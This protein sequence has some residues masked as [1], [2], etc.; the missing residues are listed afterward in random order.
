[1]TDRL[2][3]VHVVLRDLR[4]I[5]PGAATSVSTSFWVPLAQFIFGRA[6][7]FEIVCRREDHLSIKLLMPYADT[8]ERRRDDGALMFWG[9]VTPA[10]TRVVAS[11]HGSGHEGLWWWQIALTHDGDQVFVLE[12]YGERMDIFGLSESEATRVV[13]LLPLAA[14]TSRTTDG[15]MR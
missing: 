10:V 9:P 8:V 11:G 1:M 15:P 5:L 4:G 6:R 13:E 14:R 3:T 12:D 2:F 7:L